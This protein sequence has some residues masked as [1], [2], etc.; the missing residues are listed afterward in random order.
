MPTTPGLGSAP[1]KAWGLRR[2]KSIEV[3][4]LD[5]SPL[6][7]IVGANSSGKSSV[8]QS[9]L[10]LAQAAQE[11]AASPAGRFRLNGEL[12]QLGTYDLIRTFDASDDSFVVEAELGA[13]PGRTRPAVAHGQSRRGAP[14]AADQTASST[15]TGPG[16]SVG[17]RSASLAQS[18]G[19]SST[20]DWPSRAQRHRPHCISRG[21]PAARMTQLRSNAA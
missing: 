18:C 6:T 21:D 1:I 7:V 2:F 8:L 12:V 4:D 20:F 16:H 9:I 19:K 10:L 13:R 3:A 14:V 5:L 17:T 11:G 15:C